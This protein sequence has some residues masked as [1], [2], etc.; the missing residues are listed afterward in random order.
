MYT[1]A[2]IQHTCCPLTTYRRNICWAAYIQNRGGPEENIMCA[3]KCTHTTHS[4]RCHSVHFAKNLALR[5]C[6]IYSLHNYSDRSYWELFK[7]EVMSCR[8]AHAHKHTHTHNFNDL[9]LI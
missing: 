8:H 9:D 2:C 6:T 3:T 7:E 4:N 1:Q 5:S